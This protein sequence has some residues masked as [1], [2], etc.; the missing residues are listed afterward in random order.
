MAK[1][2][3]PPVGSEISKTIEHA[4]NSTI[5]IVGAKFPTEDVEEA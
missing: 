3:S 5:M 2:L 4:W 1:S